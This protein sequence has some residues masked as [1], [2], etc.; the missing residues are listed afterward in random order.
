M[1]DETSRGG[2]PSD[3]PEGTPPEPHPE[4]RPAPTPPPTNQHDVAPR[5]PQAASDNGA[6]N[7]GG[8][9]PPPPPQPF[10]SAPY[11]GPGNNPGL[12]QGPLPDDVSKGWLPEDKRQRPLSPLPEPKLFRFQSLLPFKFVNSLRHPGE[13]PWLIAAYL[14]TLFV[15]ISAGV[16]L[17]TSIIAM[18]TD[19]D[20]V[21]T[22]D[23]LIQQFIALAL[24]IPLAIF[25]VR[26]VMYAQMRINGVRITPTQFPEAY[27]ML[28]D[29]ARAAGMR[30]VPDA[31]VFL[32]NGM[33]NAFASGHGHRRF[34]VIFSD[35]FEVGGKARNPE[36]LRFIIAHEVGHIAAG[37]VGYF[38]LI[39]TSFFGSIPYLGST[40]SRAQEYTADNFGYR[41]APAGALQTIGV[42]SAGKYLCNEVNVDEVA[43]RA[44]YE[45]GFFTWLANLNSS[46]PPTTWRAHSLRDRSEPG[47]LVWRPKKNPPYPLS[48]IPAAEPVAAWADPLQATD[49]MVT[50]PELPGNEHWGTVQTVPKAPAVERDRRVADT[51]FTG[52]VPPQARG[53]WNAGGAPQPSETS[54]EQSQQPDSPGEGTPQQ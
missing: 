41:A 11:P 23:S 3:Q 39:F 18:F 16:F 19:D 9:T 25:W 30:R 32:G 4:P 37:H 22:P 45:D 47:R 48:M 7:N 17:V 15:Y 1:S 28:V 2:N 54:E 14:L 20:Y 38:R 51:L 21:F 6:G 35:L 13:I 44:V 8:G 52:W 33:I 40:L 50:Y 10:P 29:A 43:N 46:H 31:Y 5:Q 53:F 24:Y 12:A 42:L 26:A 27:A 34:I 36:A 49:F